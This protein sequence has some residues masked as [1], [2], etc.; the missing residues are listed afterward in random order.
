MVV[1]FVAG[2]KS[3]GTTK[4]SSIRHFLRGLETQSSGLQFGGAMG[5]Q[6]KA[7]I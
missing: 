2:P 3:D 1:V 4:L 5:V 7:D 6:V